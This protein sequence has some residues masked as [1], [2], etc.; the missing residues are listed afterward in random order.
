MLSR[1]QILLNYGSDTL[2]KIK[3]NDV[4]IPLLMLRYCIEKKKGFGVFKDFPFL[5]FQ[6][7][8]FDNYGSLLQFMFVK[9]KRSIH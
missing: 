1:H 4:K 8:Q 9:L 2:I 3:S 7:L 5:V 6:N